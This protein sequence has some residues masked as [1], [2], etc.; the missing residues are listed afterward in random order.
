VKSEKQEARIEKEREAKMR[1][2]SDR[3]KEEI[4]AI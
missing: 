3:F 2:F 4:T 1:V